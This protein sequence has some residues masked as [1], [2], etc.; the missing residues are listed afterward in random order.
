MRKLG[1]LL[2]GFAILVLVGCYSTETAN[3]IERRDASQAANKE[4]TSIVER[5]DGEHERY[6]G[7]FETEFSDGTRVG[8]VQSAY[9]VA[10]VPLKGTI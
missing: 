7:K 10:C 2:C 9:G 1:L 4:R 5:I 6:I 3:R 8:C